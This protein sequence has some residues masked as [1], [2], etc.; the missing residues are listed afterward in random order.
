M[1]PDNCEQVLCEL[2]FNWFHAKPECIGEKLFYEYM[3][4]K[5]KNHQSI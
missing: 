3:A 5:K 2:C 1:A 4:N